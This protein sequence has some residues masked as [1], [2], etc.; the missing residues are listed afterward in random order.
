MSLWDSTFGYA[1]TAPAPQRPRMNV[2]LPVPPPGGYADPGVAGWDW[3]EEER[4]RAAQRAA[5]ASGGT[6][7]G[8]FNDPG[9]TRPPPV[10]PMPPPG[11]PPAASTPQAPQAPLASPYGPGGSLPMT[12]QQGPMGDDR[13]L[14]TQAG[15]WLGRQTT[16]NPAA[17]TAALVEGAGKGGGAGGM[18][19]G[20]Q[21]LLAAGGRM[22]Q[23]AQPPPE[24]QVQAV[25]LPTPGNR[26]RAA[27]GSLP[28]KPGAMDLRRRRRQPQQGG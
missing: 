16:D 4:R 17:Y 14:L 7:L 3:Q 23:Q 9:D 5:Y 22:A 26:P 24:R 8:A 6:D 20:M 25:T 10:P 27:A 13:G 15:D 19:Q 2:G 11:G 21:G 1:V 28:I 12:I 18:G